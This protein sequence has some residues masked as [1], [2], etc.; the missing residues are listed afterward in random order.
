[1]SRLSLTLVIGAL[2]GAILILILSVFSGRDDKGFPQGL[3]GKVPQYEAYR[4]N[5][6]RDCSAPYPYAEICTM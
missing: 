1:M 3:R 6:D 4:T 5:D 2:L